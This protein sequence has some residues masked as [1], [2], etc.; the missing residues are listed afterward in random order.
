MKITKKMQQNLQWISILLLLATVGY[1]LINFDSNNY[2]GFFSSGAM[3]PTVFG[4]ISVYF[5][6]KLSNN[7][8]SNIPIEI[9][10]KE[11]KPRSNHGKPSITVYNKISLFSVIS[12]ILAIP[13]VVM[14]LIFTYVALGNPEHITIIYFDH[15]S[16][17]WIELIVFSIAGAVV[18]L[19]ALVNVKTFGKSK[20][21]LK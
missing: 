7:E 17:F 11:Q 10:E 18:I 1:A 9:I 6:W 20:R 4:F 12:S 15:F 2:M 5:L 21:Q 19:G 13:F 16:E 8:L 14:V 3:L